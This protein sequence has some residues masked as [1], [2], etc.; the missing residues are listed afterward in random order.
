MWT[1]LTLTDET[2]LPCPLR[3]TETPEAHDQVLTGST[4]TAGI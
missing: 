1:D 4:M 3:G 2:C